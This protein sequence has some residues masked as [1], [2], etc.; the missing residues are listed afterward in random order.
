MTKEQILA[1]CAVSQARTEILMKIRGLKETRDIKEA[2]QLI[3][4]G[5]WIAIYATSCEPYLF[6]LGRIEDQ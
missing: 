4:S 5:N 6:V 3:S 2:A 1:E